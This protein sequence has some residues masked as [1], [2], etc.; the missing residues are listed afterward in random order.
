MMRRIALLISASILVATLAYAVEPIAPNAIFAPD[1]TWANGDCP[2]AQGNKF[3]W[4][5]TCGN[6][7]SS[8]TC[9]KHHCSDELCFNPIPCPSGYVSTGIGTNGDAICELATNFIPTPTPTET[10]TPTATLTPTAT[11]TAT[12]TETVTPT[13]TASLTPTPTATASPKADRDLSYLT[14]TGAGGILPQSR[15]LSV[16]SGIDS[17]DGGP[18]NVFSLSCSTADASTKGC[19]T[20]LA[21]AFAG[22]KTFNDD[23][24][25]KDHVY[26]APTTTPTPTNTSAT[27]TPT[28][29]TSPSPTATVTGVATSTVAATVAATPTPRPEPRIVSGGRP[30]NGTCWAEGGPYQSFGSSGTGGGIGGNPIGYASAFVS[31]PFDVVVAN[32]TCTK[33]S[34]FVWGRTFYSR[35]QTALKASCRPN[36]PAT[37]NL[38]CD[39]T[40]RRDGPYCTLTG[41]SNSVVMCSSSDDLG[42]TSYSNQP[43]YVPAGTVYRLLA[44]EVPTSGSAVGTCTWLACMA[45]GPP[46]PMAP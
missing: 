11:V 16:S 40:D 44:Q 41:D 7:V 37:T 23:I 30:I 46:D 39:W 38:I 45:A 32:V 3:V 15:Q 31:W 4:G 24:T 36:W 22:D 10:A 33:N 13:A 42:V 20:T 1:H 21:Q 43:L 6:S 18:G 2:V 5:G 8:A 19:V 35:F 17:L 14:V 27:D 12:P 29:T 26:I 34:V 28:P 9:H 25:A